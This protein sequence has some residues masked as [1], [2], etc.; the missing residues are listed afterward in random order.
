MRS[1]PN[2]KDTFNVHDYEDN[3]NTSGY[4]NSVYSGVGDINNPPVFQPEQTQKP[5]QTPQQNFQ[6]PQNL[7]NQ[8]FTPPDSSYLIG[9]E[10]YKQDEKTG[11]WEPSD[12][13][14]ESMRHFNAEH[15]Q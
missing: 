13:A 12:A 2:G 3:D 6:P 11:A 14:V 4:S 8:P 5:Q 7:Q 15:P 1:F 9:A 10:H